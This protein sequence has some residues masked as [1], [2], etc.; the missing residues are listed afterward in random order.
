MTIAR[1]KHRRKSKRQPKAKAKWTPIDQEAAEQLTAAT[2]APGVV[3]PVPVSALP[4]NLKPM[5]GVVSYFVSAHTAPIP[6]PT[7][8]V[9]G[10]MAVVRTDGGV[11]KAYN[12]VF[13]TSNNGQV[14][15]NGPYKDFPQ[16]HFDSTE[17]I[18]LFTI[19]GH[20]PFKK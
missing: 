15:F 7:L 12:Y 10:E 14:C 6:T 19:F 11:G 9:G 20:T 13:A 18:I 8:T 4:K 2:T 16:H 1:T 17:P 3:F 5:P